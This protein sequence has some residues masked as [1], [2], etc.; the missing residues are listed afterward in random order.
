ML[1]PVVNIALGL[2]LIIGGSTG[3]LGFMGS[4]EMWIPVL[5]G[6][7]VAGYGVI[8]VVREVRRTRP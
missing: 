8:Q 7:L 2:A 4:S 6:V 3:R 5:V 1:I